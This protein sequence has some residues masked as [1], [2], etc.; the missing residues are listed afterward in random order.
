MITDSEQ[1]SASGEQ[2]LLD[3]IGYE[4]RCWDI[5]RRLSV[6]ELSQRLL[7]VVRGWEAGGVAAG[8]NPDTGR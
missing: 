5:D 6:A 7:K 1:A 4:V 8:E 2:K 3:E